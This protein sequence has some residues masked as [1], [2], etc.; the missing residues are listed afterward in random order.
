MAGET[1]I[2]VIGGHGARDACTTLLPQILCG[3]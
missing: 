3:R 2:T 1:V